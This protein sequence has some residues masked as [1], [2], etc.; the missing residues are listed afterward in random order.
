MSVKNPP[1]RPSR[2]RRR[3]LLNAEEEALWAHV[4]KQV[5]PLRP[6]PRAA[7]PAEAPPVPA[8]AAAAAA[9]KP[10]AEPKARTGSVRPPAAKPLAPLEPKTRRR[11]AR[12]AQVGLQV[13]AR[14]DLHGLTQAA[15]H[16]RLRHFLADAR[17]AGHGLVLVITGKGSPRS[18]EAALP[19][20]EERGVLRRA[21]PHWLAGADLR[22]IVLGFEE[23]GPR[24]GGSGALYVRLRRRD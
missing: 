1:A 24:H 11:L 16:Q 23:A 18:F 10:V 4:V 14:I 6:L 13:G 19:F 8:P 2:G 9:A 5:V 17:H 20:G 7:A 22:A 12:G 21:V 3:R 15:A